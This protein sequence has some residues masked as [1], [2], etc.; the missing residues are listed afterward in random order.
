M[1]LEPD[2]TKERLPRSIT[3]V[4]RHVHARVVDVR[5]LGRPDAAEFLWRRQTFGAGDARIM[6][7]VTGE[8][9][10]TVHFNCPWAPPLNANRC[11]LQHAH[12]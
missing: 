7:M 5:D 3:V 9:P 6:Q 1:P 2:P 12:T 11:Q 4:L 10:T 8:T